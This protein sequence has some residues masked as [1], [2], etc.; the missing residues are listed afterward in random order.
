MP[1]I[2]LLKMELIIISLYS[3]RLAI[4]SEHKNRNFRRDLKI[5]FEIH[6]SETKNSVICLRSLIRCKTVVGT[7]QT[8]CVLVQFSERS[9]LKKKGI[10]TFMKLQVT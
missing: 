4:G 5:H 1:G 9:L 6:Y 3:G 10:F 7:A 2:Q 8:D